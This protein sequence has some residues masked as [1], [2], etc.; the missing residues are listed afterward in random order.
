MERTKSTA[1][2]AAVERKHVVLPIEGMSCATCAGRVEKAISALPGVTATVNL[3]SEHADVEYD[4]SQVSPVALAEAVVGAGYE[5]R[6]ETR[7]LAISDMSCATCAGRVEAALKQVPGVT[8]SEVNLASEKAAVEGIAGVLRPSDLIAAVRKAGYGAELLTGDRERDEAI[9]AAEDR[10]LRRETWRIIAAVVLSAPLLLPMFG[11]M[12]PGWLQFALATPVQFGVGWRF[13]IG[14]WRALRARTG[15]MDLLVS[16]GTSA[17]Y[18]YSVYLMLAGPPGGHL[19]FEAAA[20]VIALIMVGRW[21]E[22]RAKRSTTAAIRALM[23]LRPERARIERDGGEIE[24]P[25]ADVAVGEIVVVRPGERIPVDATVL[26]GRSEV[27]ES[28]LTGESLP[29]PKAAGDKIIG[30]SINGSGLLRAQASA[31]GEQSSLSRIIA[32]VE[33]AQTKKPPVQRLVDRVAAVFV[34]I[35]LAI[36]LAAFLGW[37]LMVGDM[38]AGVVA[39]VSVLVIACPCSLG[40]ATPTALMVGTG[41]AAKAGILIRDAEALERTHRLDTIIFDKTG[42]ITEGRPAVTEIVCHGVDEAQLLAL[43]G[44]AQTG[45]EHPLARAVLM[46]AKGLSF[47]KLVDFQSHT[48][49]G[50]TANV[51]G[52]RIVIG[53]RRLMAEHGVSLDPLV[54]EAARLEERGRTVMWVAEL[55][56]SAELLGII[57]VADP[58]KPTAS[59]AVRHLHDI[60]IETVLLTGDNERTAAAVAAQVGIDRVLAGVLPGEKSNEVQR[61]QKEGRRVGMVGDGVND[62]PALAAADVGIAMGTGADVAM[63]TAGITL[64]RGDPLLVGNAISV[65]RATYNKIRQGLFWAFIYNVVGLPLAAFGLLSPVI[66]GA[67]M[68]LSSVSVVT[69]ALLLRR[70]R[71]AGVGKASRV[72]KPSDPALTAVTQVGG[73]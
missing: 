66:A 52:R 44:A 43:S 71:P 65:S 69:N 32:L 15:N 11:M 24:V 62:A 63:E 50:L 68:A 55:T 12:L 33:H 27:D 67:A 58:V 30:G 35:V 49:L 9:V 42:M 38:T 46:K 2:S 20:V 4:G 56:T 73:P 47:P 8:H 23:S 18:F 64:M 22:V 28:L 57:A 36:A 59:D 70:W 34:P 60:G 40:L 10:R 19:Y 37:W 6:R 1:Q 14:A 7:K 45:S 29:V 54:A 25:V 26:T 53:N 41:A 39:A 5:V 17:A 51:D 21:L 48:G 72:V 61:L 3:A 31:V 13:Y 16:L